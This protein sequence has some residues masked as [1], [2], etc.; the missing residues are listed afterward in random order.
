ME[1]HGRVVSSPDNDGTYWYCQTVRARQA[2]REAVR[3]EPAP[4]S[5]VTL[6]TSPKPGGSGLECSARPAK[7]RWGVSVIGKACRSGGHGEGLRR[8]H[9]DAAGAQLGGSLDNRT[10][11][12]VGSV[13]VSPPGS[14][15]R[16]GS[17]GEARRRPRASGCGGVLVVVAGVTTRHGDRES[18]SQG[19]GGQ[20][21]GSGRTGMPGG[22]RR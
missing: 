4:G 9:G 12:N 22:G 19:Q 21:V 15:N 16:P 18:R 7:G 1:T 6:D 10:V 13:L 17:R 5:P 8:S 11:V 3:E 2:R 14:G 20:Q